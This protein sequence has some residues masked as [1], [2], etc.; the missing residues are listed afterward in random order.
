MAII[1]LMAAETKPA[2]DTFGLGKRY[3]RGAD[4]ALHKLNITIMPG[5]V[6]GYLGPNGAGKSTTIRL[7][8]NFIQPSEGHAHILGKD[9]VK[10]SVDIKRRVGYLPGEFAYYPGMTGRQFLNYMAELQ[11]PRRKT[12]V[13]ELARRFDVPLNRKLNTLSKGN[14]QKIGV[15][16]AFASQP[17]VLILDE[18]TSGLDPLMQE[19]FF[20][21]V[22]E[23]KDRGATIFFS[24]HNLSEVQKICDR[25]GFIRDGEL[26]AEQTI[27]Q[28]SQSAVQTYDIAF[29]GPSPLADLRRLKGAKITANTPHHV[30]IRL[31]GELKPLFSLLAK[32]KVVSIDRREIDL[33]AEFLQ[34]YRRGK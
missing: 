8:M 21:L 33:E 9:I 27:S 24:S 14:R 22:R 6:Y 10:D 2:I 11:P 18:P 31:K 16:Q 32:Q 3:S 26:I 4:F 1:K 20:Q 13:S 23:S 7:L 5:E 25:V 28:L 30:T 12:Y 29:A 19:S 15:I 17:D 34:Y